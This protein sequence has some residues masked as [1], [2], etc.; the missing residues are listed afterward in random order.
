VEI[1]VL[2]V[3]SYYLSFNLKVG[4]MDGNNVSLDEDEHLMSTTA[5]HKSTNVG[6]ED[7]DM[8]EFSGIFIF[9]L[10]EHVR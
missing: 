7:F 10:F 9:S 2:S 1:A 8:D 5:V 3:A 6:D 4:N